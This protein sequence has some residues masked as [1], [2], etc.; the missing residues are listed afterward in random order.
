M[1]LSHKRQK[2]GQFDV[3]LVDRPSKISVQPSGE[4]LFLEWNSTVDDSGQLGGCVKGRVPR[5]D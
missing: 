2:T 1:E 5:L 4:E 3:D